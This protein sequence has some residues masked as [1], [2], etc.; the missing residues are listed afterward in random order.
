MMG[1]GGIDFSKIAQQA[2]EMKAKLET[3]DEELAERVVE[4]TSGGGMVKVRANGAQEIVDVKIE[5]QVINPADKGM[6]EDLVIA[7]VNEA[8]KK[9]KKLRE[10]EMKKVTGGLPLPGMF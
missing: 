7:G 9:S 4:G 5:P 6:L 10:D 3:I 1:G 8:L 2:R